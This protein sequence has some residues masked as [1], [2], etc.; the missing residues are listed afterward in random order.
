MKVVLI[1]G[2]SSGIGAATA[3][4]FAAAGAQVIL[5]ARSADRLATLVDEIGDNAIAIPLDASDAEAV[6]S[7]RDTV[8]SNYGAPDV[9][10]HSAGA[11]LWKTLPDTTP[12]EAQIMMNAPYFAAFTVTQAFLPAMLERRKGVIISIN[13]PA[14]Y[15]AWPS[16]VGYAAARSA[17]RGFSEALAQDLVGTGVSACH[18]VF[19]K[20]SNPRYSG[21]LGI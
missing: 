21:R 1:T 19:G 17:I 12:A 9:L 10:I 7:L 18:A 8:L 5:V 20:S 14:C 4:R 2:A 11:G 13:S 15:F 3:R 6:T 16:S